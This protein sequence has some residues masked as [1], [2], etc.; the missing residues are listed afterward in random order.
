MLKKIL[1]CH[2]HDPNLSFQLIFL[3]VNVRFQWRNKSHK[4]ILHGTSVPLLKG[5]SPLAGR[6]CCWQVTFGPNEMLLARNETIG[7]AWLLD[8][9]HCRANRISFEKKCT[10]RIRQASRLCLSA[11]ELMFYGE[12]IFEICSSIEIWQIQTKILIEMTDLDHKNDNLKHF[13]D[14]NWNLQNNPWKCKTNS[15]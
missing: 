14:K 13:F 5:K 12:S 6:R 10:C 9:C 4:R 11:K 3:F 15:F 2:F 1:H 7:G 8:T